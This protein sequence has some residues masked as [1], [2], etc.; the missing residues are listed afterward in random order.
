MRSGIKLEAHRPLDSTE[1]GARQA[2]EASSGSVS[3]LTHGSHW[4]I[5]AVIICLGR[6]RLLKICEKPSPIN[7]KAATFSFGKM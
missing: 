3:A 1:R 5:S 6:D 2:D 7:P 4:D